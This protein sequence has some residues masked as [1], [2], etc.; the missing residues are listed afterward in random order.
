[1]LQ[2]ELTF[3]ASF[4]STPISTIK[5]LRYALQPT[6]LKTSEAMESTVKWPESDKQQATSTKP[7][8]ASRAASSKP[9]PPPQGHQQEQTKKFPAPAV[10]Q[11]IVACP[12]WFVAGLSLLLLACSLPRRRSRGLILP[13]RWV[14]RSRRRG[15]VRFVQLRSRGALERKWNTDG[16]KN[17]IQV[18]MATDTVT[19][20]APNFRCIVEVA[21]D[22]RSLPSPHWVI[23]LRAVDVARKAITFTGVARR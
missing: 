6:S 1:M 9:E 15:A 4:T 19:T 8:I 12:L 7:E 17:M 13:C 23:T 20:T 11:G 5:A 22:R 21:T 3:E 14:G 18:M 16:A 10:L 2:S